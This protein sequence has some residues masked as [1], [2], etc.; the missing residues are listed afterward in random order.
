MLFLAEFFRIPLFYL[1]LVSTFIIELSS[2]TA[3]ER[4]VLSG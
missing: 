1:G 4:S 2:F 3:Y